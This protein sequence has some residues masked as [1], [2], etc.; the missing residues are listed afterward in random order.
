[1][2]EIY[3]YDIIWED[4]EGV[5]YQ[6]PYYLFATIGKEEADVILK[7][8]F[9]DAVDFAFLRVANFIELT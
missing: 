7:Q 2:N 6:K 4:S 1:M 3:V 9:P 5:R 8:K